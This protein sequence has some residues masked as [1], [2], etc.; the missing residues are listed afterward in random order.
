MQKNNVS[1]QIANPVS[2][3][4]LPSERGVSYCV[5]SKYTPG[6]ILNNISSYGLHE[7]PNRVFRNDVLL[8]TSE[9][10]YS[11]TKKHQTIGAEAWYYI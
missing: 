1:H 8:Q 9:L 7:T 10:Y 4:V 11:L 3:L 2:A 6:V 5:Q